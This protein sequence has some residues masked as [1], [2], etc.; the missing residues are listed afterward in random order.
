MLSICNGSVNV[1]PLYV[2]IR[3]FDADKCLIAFMLLMPFYI[4]WDCLSYF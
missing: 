2:S 4:F 3:M 1:A